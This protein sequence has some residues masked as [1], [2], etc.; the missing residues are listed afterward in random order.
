MSYPP[1]VVAKKENNS[2]LSAWHG[3]EYDHSAIFGNLT[4]Q[5]P[6]KA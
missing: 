1:P 4:P 5:Q 3:F 2:A 6:A